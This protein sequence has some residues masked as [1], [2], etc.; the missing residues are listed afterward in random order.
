MVN[1]ITVSHILVEKYETAN[2][3]K[4]EI[5]RENFAKLAKKHSLCPSKKV[6]GSLGSFGR[7]QM[8]KEFETVAF[9]LKIGE[10]SM[11]TKTQFGYHIILRTK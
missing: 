1:K 9:G 5:K 3:L 10:I 7:G 6:N 8:V 11:P 4:R 2:K